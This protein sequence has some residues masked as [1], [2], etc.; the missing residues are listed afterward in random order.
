MPLTTN[1]IDLSPEEL[2]QRLIVGFDSLDPRSRP[3]NLLRTQFSKVLAAAKWNLIGLTSAT[4]SA[5]KTFTSLNLAAALSRTENR[6]IILCD[7]DLRR[8]SIARQIGLKPE[9]ALDD[10]LRGKI[11]DWKEALLAFNSD[12]LLLLPVRASNVQSGEFL[13]GEVFA[14]MM[15]DLLA[16]SKTHL[17]LCDMPPVFANDDAMLTAK[18]LDAYLFI[19]DHGRTTKRQIEEALALLAPTPCLGTVLNRYSGGFADDYGYGYGDAYGLRV[20][21]DATARQ[22]DN[23]A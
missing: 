16:L 17:I 20:Y 18:F 23:A 6:P 12:K 19:V 11:A 22:E 21:A 14:N 2:D 1:R 9:V 4:P 3:F 13:A 5:G 10:Y 7:F 8:G 15:A